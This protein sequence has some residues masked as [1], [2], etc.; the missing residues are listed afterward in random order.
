MATAPW[1]ND[2]TADPKEA[3]SS[4]PWAADAP[5]VPTEQPTDQL[6]AAE[7][8]GA[9]FTDEQK[10]AILAYIPHA[11]DPADLKQFSL[12]ISGGRAQI[13]NAKDILEKRDQGAEQFSWLPPVVNKDMAAVKPDTL[14]TIRNAIGDAL[15]SAITPGASDQTREAVKRSGTAFTEHAANAFAADYGPEVGGLIDTILHGGNVATNAERERAVME[16]DSAD[17]PV[18]SIAGELTGA[19]LVAPLAGTA[20]KA[21]PIVAKAAQAAP[22][23]TSAAEAAAGGAAYGSGAAGPDNRAG[24]AVT[25]ATIGAV[26]D[27]T[28]PIISRYLT[29]L[30]SGAQN[31]ASGLYPEAAKA[32]QA[33]GIDLPKFVVGS[34]KDARKAAALEQTA[35]GA[36]PI[37]AATNRMLDQSEAARNTIAA[38]LGT[39]ASSPA[40]MG[41]QALNAAVA[42]N[43]DLRAAGGALY[44][45][46]RDAAAGATIPP[47]QTLTNIDALLAEENSKIGGS[48][49]APILQR[50]RDDLAKAGQITVQ[51]ARDL[52]TDLREQ[53]S[54]DADATPDK[55]DR[56]VKTVM[57]GVNDDMGN[58]LS[59]AGKKGAFALY[60][61][62]DANWAQQRELEDSVLKPFLGKNFDNWGEDVAQRIHA[63]AKGHGTR[64][65]RFLGTL[66]ED[67]AN[68][69]RANLVLRLGT[70][71]PGAQ[72]AAGNAFSLDTFLTNWNELKGSRGLV[73]PKETV[74]SLDQLAQVAQVAKSFGRKLNRSNTGGVVSYL[75]HG[76]PTALG[77][78][79]A[80]FTHDPQLLAYGMMLSAM[81]AVKQYG[82]ARLLASPAFA[83]KLA[84]TP[85]NPAGAASFW[86]RPWVQRLQ[87]ENPSIAAEIQAFQKAFLSG[88]NDNVGTLSSAAAQPQKQNQQ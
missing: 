61:E 52:R 81:R 17:H 15:L 86:S 57:A 62:A 2:P 32:A 87:L 3:A 18:A 73:F 5:V 50:Y 74:Q 20:I 55:T 24:G 23:L 4:Q 7:T 12:Q 21:V 79:G 22:K 80:I 88:A 75:T 37:T 64:L 83:R 6:P 42:R 35:M 28:L 53:L 43:K 26:T 67:E 19:G 78:G 11:K 9:D 46:A 47:T 58:G 30:K 56:I 49:I 16:G 10:K 39:A 69:V 38:H 44:D 27:A 59:A 70:A 41:D 71:K 45:Q 40:Q 84:A 68:R 1:E 85:K 36:G 33:L 82:A 60:S 31:T 66:P 65:A 14:E 48:K 63:D 29:A 72:D 8:E 34:A 25:G 51:Q 54:A 76:A 77:A 13:G